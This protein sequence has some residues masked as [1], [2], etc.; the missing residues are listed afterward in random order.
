MNHVINK[1]G[2]DPAGYN[3]QKATLLKDLPSFRLKKIRVL[4][5]AQHSFVNHGASYKIWELGS[6]S[7]FYIG[8]KMMTS[9]Q[10][11]ARFVIHPLGKDPKEITTPKVYFC[12]DNKGLWRLIAEDENNK[13]TASIPIM[14][15]RKIEVHT[16]VEQDPKA[17]KSWIYYSIEKSGE[18]RAKNVIIMDKLEVPFKF[19]GK[20]IVSFQL[21]PGKLSKLI[22]SD[23]LM[24]GDEPSIYKWNIP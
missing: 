8:F 15:N 21:P 23:L 20:L 22:I 11:G 18:N 1:Q 10:P 17:L 6:L 13:K 14:F 9:F 24:A 3:R 12:I 5:S 19:D 7:N 2:Y 4:S 16:A